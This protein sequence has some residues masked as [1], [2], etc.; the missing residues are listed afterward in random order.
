MS[1]KPE[2]THIIGF[3]GVLTLVISVADCF[4][5]DD[6][7]HPSHLFRVTVYFLF[8]LKLLW[9]HL[10]LIIEEMGKEIEF[11]DLRNTIP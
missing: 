8:H 4:K 2:F 6:F 10:L 3:K 7:L 5:L 9:E 11:V 1:A